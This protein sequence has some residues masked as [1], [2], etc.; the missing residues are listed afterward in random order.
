MENEKTLVLK[1]V[2]VIFSELTDKGFGRNIVINADEPEVQEAIK[3]WV[4][5][6]NINGGEAKFKDY[7]NKD[8][9]TTKQ[10]TFKLSEYTDIKYKSAE[11]EE[12]GG[13]GYGS[14]INLQAR[15]YEYDNKFGKGI[16]ASLDAI[17]VIEAG[18]N[19]A[20]ANIAE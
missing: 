10:Y 6:N 20:M 12:K 7:T 9:V 18:K 19:N 13:L 17:F 16:S 3:T 1:H 14:V 5:K 8:G 11:V 4:A 2:S 15:A